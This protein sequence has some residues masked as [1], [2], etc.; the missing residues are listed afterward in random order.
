MLRHISTL[1]RRPKTTDVGGCVRR[2]GAC[3]VTT[4][5][6]G[7]CRAPGQG[8]R[9]SRIFSRTENSRATSVDRQVDRVRPV[10]RGWPGLTGCRLADQPSA[11]ASAGGHRMVD[12]MFGLCRCSTARL[13]SAR[14]AALHRITARPF[15][16]F[17]RPATVGTWENIA[18]TRPMAAPSGRCTRFGSAT[19]EL[20]TRSAPG[21]VGATGT[22]VSAWTRSATRRSGFSAWRAGF[23][24]PAAASAS[25]TRY[26][27]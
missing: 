5:A 18:A 13:A 20:G 1:T 25:A 16:R 21:A 6:A 12:P 9:R 11:R 4:A 19:F 14:L 17:A 7:D 23:G 27:W 8:F 26:I 10:P 22:A 3:E 2:D 24:A 15:T